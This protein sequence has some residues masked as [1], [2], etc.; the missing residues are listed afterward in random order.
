M[1]VNAP[2]TCKALRSPL[3]FDFDSMDL[4]AMITAFSEIDK[5]GSGELSLEELTTC[6]R[7]TGK[8]DHVIEHAL[9]RLGFGPPL[10]DSRQPAEGESAASWQSSQPSQ[11]FSIPHPCLCLLVHISTRM[12]VQMCMHMSVHRVFHRRPRRSCPPRSAV[13]IRR[14]V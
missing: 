8:P 10:A 1:L 3:G 6:M 12:T 2:L 4:D 14:R 11:T 13:H 9:R 5:D 7:A